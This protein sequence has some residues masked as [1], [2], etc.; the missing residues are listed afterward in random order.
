MEGIIGDE[1]DEGSD[2]KCFKDFLDNLNDDHL[3]DGT[4][5]EVV[6]ELLLYFLGQFFRGG[7]DVAYSFLLSRTRVAYTL[8]TLTRINTFAR[9]VITLIRTFECLAT[10]DGFN[11]A[12]SYVTGESESER[13]DT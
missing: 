9:V 7:S 13:T 8:P 12:T 10:I 11:R 5:H 1:S 3:H 6:V 4:R 2:E